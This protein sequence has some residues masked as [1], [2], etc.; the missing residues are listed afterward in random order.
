MSRL[1]FIAFFGLSSAEPREGY[2]KIRCFGLDGSFGKCSIYFDVGP[3]VWSGT[4]HDA[5]Y[6]EDS[7]C[8]AGKRIAFG[9]ARAS[10]WGKSVRSEGGSLCV[11][12]V[13]SLRA[14]G[15]SIEW[16]AEDFKTYEMKVRLS[17]HAVTRGSF[18]AS[19]GVEVAS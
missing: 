9:Y 16:Q 3:A 4:L 10:Y 7:S 19:A 8:S 18:L 11:P 12:T 5:T 14:Q 1:I 13:G 2:G 15:G 6:E 17:P